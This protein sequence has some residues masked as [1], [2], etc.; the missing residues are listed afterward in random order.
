MSTVDAVAQAIKEASVSALARIR[1]GG[2]WPP[3]DYYRDGGPMKAYVVTTSDDYEPTEV[4]RIYLDKDEADNYAERRNQ[5][6]NEYRYAWRVEEWD[7]GC[8]AEYDGPGYRIN[9]NCGIRMPLPDGDPQDWRDHGPY[10]HEEWLTGDYLKPVVHV[11]P[12]GKDAYTQRFVSVVGINKDE[13]MKVL[14]DA[15][16]RVRAE[17]AVT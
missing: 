7:V 8:P 1:G 14:G 11:T 5:G 2:N 9:W 16:A 12:P 3:N 13:L 4:E 17:R 10:V 15:V 6:P